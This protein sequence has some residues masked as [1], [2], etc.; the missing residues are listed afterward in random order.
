MCYMILKVLIIDDDFVDSSI[1]IHMLKKFNCLIK[2]ASN[3]KTALDIIGDHDF[4][5]IIVDYIMPDINGLDLVYII[6]KKY[7]DF[8]SKIFMVSSLPKIKILDTFNLVDRF[9]QKPLQRLD[10]I[11]EMNR[12]F[13]L[14]K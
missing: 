8:D 11:E 2:T 10:F 9:F 7:P 6:K 13:M 3:G 5:L 12:Y 14:K 4:H 1:I